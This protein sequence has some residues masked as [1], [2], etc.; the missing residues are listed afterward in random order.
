MKDTLYYLINSKVGRTALFVGVCYVGYVYIVDLTG[1]F[2]R[3]KEVKDV[4]DAM[5][6]VPDPRRDSS[7]IIINKSVA[8]SRRGSL[9]WDYSHMRPD[10]ASP[11]V[12]PSV[13]SSS[14][15]S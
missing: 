11:D 7:T 10:F 1:V 8:E 13:S 9:I 6:K 2:E 15:A 5:P 14:V 4:A 3:A 12:S